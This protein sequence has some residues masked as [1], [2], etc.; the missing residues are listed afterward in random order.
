M[1][2]IS[3][4]ERYLILDAIEDEVPMSLPVRLAISSLVQVAGNPMLSPEYKGKR[5]ARL[6]EDLDQ[7]FYADRERPR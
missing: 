5:V 4:N 7:L 6:Y 1:K 3:R 2:R